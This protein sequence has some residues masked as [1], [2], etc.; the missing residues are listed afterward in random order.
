MKTTTVKSAQPELPSGKAQRH[1]S[2]SAASGKTPSEP[3]SAPSILECAQLL[4]LASNNVMPLIS[5][6][7][8]IDKR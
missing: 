8:T 2:L 5:D 1:N 3:H 4:F 7:S 6:L